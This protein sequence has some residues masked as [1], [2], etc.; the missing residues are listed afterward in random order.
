M[1]DGQAMA[2]GDA[3]QVKTFATERAASVW[4][5]GFRYAREI[6]LLKPLV[7]ARLADGTGWGVFNPDYPS[8]DYLFDDRG[9]ITRRREGR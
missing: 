8:S 9:R 6:C 7:V 5:E 4:A 2:V 1:F 3:L